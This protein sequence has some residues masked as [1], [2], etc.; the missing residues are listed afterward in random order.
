[1]SC[2]ITCTFLIPTATWLAI[3][4]PSSTR[5]ASLGDEQADQLAVRDERDGEARAPTSPCELGAELGEPERL[6]RA[7]G[8]GV[9]RDPVEL[10]AR[11]VEQVDVARARARAAGARPGRPSASELVERV[12]AR[13]R[14]REL[15][16]LL[17]LG[18]AQARLLVQAR[19]LDRA[20]DE[21]RRRDDEVDLVV[22]ELARR[23]RVRGDRADRLAGAP[24]DRHGEERLEPLLLELRHVLHPRVGERVVADERRLAVLDRPPREALAALE[25]DL[26]GLALVRRRGRPEDEP[27]RRPRAR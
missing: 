1:M 6:T 26:A 24:D 19:V 21:R 27:R 16:E 20:R 9:A 8:L 12:R 25:R 2:S 23:L 17:E 11:G 22:G 5:V 18:D 7:P 10:L 14:L 13:D 4:R 3:A 15:R